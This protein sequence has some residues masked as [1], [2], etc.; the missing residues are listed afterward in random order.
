MTKKLKKI[1]LYKIIENLLLLKI[2]Y[3]K[4]NFKYKF[5]YE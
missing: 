3:N 5:Q 4:L 1:V 2:I